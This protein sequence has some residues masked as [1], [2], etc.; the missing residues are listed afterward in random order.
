MDI[1]PPN[2]G[3]RAV[4]KTIYPTFDIFVYFGLICIVKHY[5]CIR[6]K[7]IFYDFIADRPKPYGLFGGEQSHIYLLAP[8]SVLVIV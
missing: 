4:F 8:I 1:P 6:H 7:G 3:Y 2:V 5:K